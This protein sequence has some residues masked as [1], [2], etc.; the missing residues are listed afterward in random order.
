MTSH[1][2]FSVVYNRAILH[3]CLSSHHVVTVGSSTHGLAHWWVPH[4]S[5]IIR[6]ILP[7]GDC[8]VHLSLYWD[9]QRLHHLH[10]WKNCASFPGANPVQVKMIPSYD[11]DKEHECPSAE[12][13]WQMSLLF[14]HCQTSQTSK[15]LS[16]TWWSKMKGEERITSRAGIC[17][18]CHQSLQLSSC[19]GIS[20]MCYGGFGDCLVR[21]VSRDRY[22][23]CVG[24]PSAEITIEAE[25]LGLEWVSNQHRGFDP[26]TYTASVM[27]LMPRFLRGQIHPMNY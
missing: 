14:Q 15:A 18:R 19:R 6:V 25:Q 10:K 8:L 11:E 27:M 5:Y 4:F 23:L 17:Q 7:W 13:G 21:A 22:I 2:P 24:W 16:T 20:I 26:A 12:D 3:Q 9:K 1:F